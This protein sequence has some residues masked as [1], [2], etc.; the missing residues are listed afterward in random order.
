M[1]FE[2]KDIPWLLSVQ[3]FF[4]FLITISSTSSFNPLSCFVSVQGIANTLLCFHSHCYWSLSNPDLPWFYPLLKLTPLLSHLW[5]ITQGSTLNSLSRCLLSL[6]F[7]PGV[8]LTLLLL[9]RGFP[10][11]SDKIK[12][13]KLRSKSF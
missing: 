2:M 13:Y 8:Y 4:Y 5:A 1:K 10:C 6:Y 12:T 7:K 11:L 9:S 3:F